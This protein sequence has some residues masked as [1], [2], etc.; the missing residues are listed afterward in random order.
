MDFFKIVLFK[1]SRE[2]KLDLLIGDTPILDYYRANDPGCTL[3]TVDVIEE[4]NYAVGMTKGL[5]LQVLDNEDKGRI[6]N[7]LLLL[8]SSSSV[9]NRLNGFRILTR[10]L[11][12]V[13]GCLDEHLV[14]DLEL[15]DVRLHG[16]T[17]Q[18]VVQLL[19]VRPV[20]SR[21]LPASTAGCLGCSWSLHSTRIRDPGRLFDL[22][23]RAFGLQ[24]RS[25]R[26]SATTQRHHLAVAQHDVLQSSK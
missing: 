25:A 16:R 9:M 17:A 14:L 5:R 22:G 15:F 13:F 2:G 3:R 6:G 20:G 4:D 8:S 26:P 21:R 11:V 1:K 12:V 18:Q 19:T 24:I 7:F 23:C 10:S